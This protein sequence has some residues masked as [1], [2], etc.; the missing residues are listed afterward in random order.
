[1][2]SQYITFIL[3]IHLLLLLVFNINHANFNGWIFITYL[4][5][6]DFFIFRMMPLI[7][8]HFKNM[9]I[10][11]IRLPV[12]NIFAVGRPFPGLNQAKFFFINPAKPTIIKIIISAVGESSLC[13]ACYIINEKVTF[14]L[15]ANL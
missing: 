4:W 11:L 3:Y 13:F 1:V 9:D 2:Q 8:S 5:I 12:G 10:A 6:G 7:V 15:V 14:P